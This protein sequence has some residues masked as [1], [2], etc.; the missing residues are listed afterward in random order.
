MK[1]TFIACLILGAFFLSISSSHAAFCGVTDVTAN[2]SDA[3]SCS[4]QSGNDDSFATKIN[5]TFNTD[6]G[7]GQLDWG[8]AAKI[9]MDD[10]K[11][12]LNLLA[13]PGKTGTWTYTGNDPLSSPFVIVLKAS[14]SFAAYL[15]KDLADLVNGAEGT[16]EISFLNGGQKVPKLSHMTIYSTNT[17]AVPLPAAL[18]LFGPA[19]LGFM[20]LRKKNQS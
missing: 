15:F 4:N 20:G 6:L 14:N 1:K 8:I 7:G 3:F 18:W 10:S 16:F 11:N 17:S 2:G 5:D 12:N 13:T 9:D 19:L